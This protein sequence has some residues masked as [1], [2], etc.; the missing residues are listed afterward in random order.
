[1]LRIRGTISRSLSFNGVTVMSLFLLLFVLATVCVYSVWRRHHMQPVQYPVGQI[2][3]LPWGEDQRNGSSASTGPLHVRAC[4]HSSHLSLACYWLACFCLL[5][6]VW[7]SDHLFPYSESLFSKEICSCAGAGHWQ[8]GHGE[9][10]WKVGERLSHQA[11]T[12]PYPRKSQ[13]KTMTYLLR[14]VCL[15]KC[16]VY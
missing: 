4:K 7:I 9:M 6:C 15:G 5:K 12:S 13:S 1:M 11:N 10:W 8:C 16:A 3:L 14:C 2:W